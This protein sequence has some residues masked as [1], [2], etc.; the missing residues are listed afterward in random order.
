MYI[1]S[2]SYL[3]LTAS[4]LHFQQ[5]HTEFSLPSSQW[6]HRA[7]SHFHIIGADGDGNMVCTLATGRYGL[8][9]HRALSG[10]A[11]LFHLPVKFVDVDQLV[12][13]RCSRWSVMNLRLIVGRLF[14]AMQ[15]KA[16]FAVLRP[17]LTGASLPQAA[18]RRDQL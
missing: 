7:P 5:D 6:W 13:T 2:H 15:M 1:G 12:R 3:P 4:Y 11:E 9:Y 17:L 18:N 8:V 14:P 10:I 16:A